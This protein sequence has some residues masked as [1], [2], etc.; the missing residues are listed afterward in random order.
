MPKIQII[1]TMIILIALVGWFVVVRTKHV[2]VV[3]TPAA[4]TQPVGETEWPSLE[5]KKQ[6]IS[7]SNQY[8]SIDAAYPATKDPRISS[9]MKAFIDDQI[10][11]F[12]SDTSWAIDPATSSAAEGSLSLGI[13]YTEQ[14]STRAD[15]YIFDISTY[16]GG[17]HG[18]EVNKTFSYD[19][20]GKLINLADLFTNGE[21]G[22]KTIAPFVQSEITKKN[23]SDPD[24]IKDGAAATAE[25]YQSFVI[26]D[27]GITFIFDAYQVAPY[28]AGTQKIL[29]PVSVFK[30]IANPDLFAK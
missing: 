5:T 28:A 21:A 19:K 22:L 20:N 10:T 12:K 29:V 27:D 26:A 30:S 24:W 3:E 2:P 1:F 7:D 15:N 11:Q 8:Y 23:I 4:V 16:T 13:N 18:L 14:K 6:T 25:N 17:A 9:S